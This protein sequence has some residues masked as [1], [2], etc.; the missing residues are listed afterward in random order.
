MKAHEQNEN[1]KPIKCS[2]CGVR[3]EPWKINILTNKT[4]KNYKHTGLHNLHVLRQA[5]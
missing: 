4:S 3:P 5:K 2:P 1:L